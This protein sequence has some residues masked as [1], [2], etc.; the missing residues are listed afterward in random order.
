MTK[1]IKSK[2]MGRVMLGRDETGRIALMFSLGKGTEEKSYST[3]GGVALHGRFIHEGKATITLVQQRVQV[4]LHKADRHSL[5]TFMR[6][7]LSKLEAL[8]K[9]KQA[10]DV[11]F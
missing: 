6:F 9:K 3:R 11:L 5:D 8:K 4:M 10:R 1:Q 7:F 2:G